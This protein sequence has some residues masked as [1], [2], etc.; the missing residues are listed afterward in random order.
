MNVSSVIAAWKICVSIVMILM[1]ELL[2][3]LVVE[4]QDTDKSHYIL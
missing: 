2:Q 4:A 1:E 3:H